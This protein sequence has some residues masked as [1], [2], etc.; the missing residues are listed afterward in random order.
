MSKYFRYC[1]I[2]VMEAIH[3]GA[4][5][6]IN[7]H[8]N[9]LS[10]DFVLVGLLEQDD[11][12]AM[13]TIKEMGL[14]AEEIKEQ[15]LEI[16]DRVYSSRESRS[17]GTKTLPLQIFL[18]RETDDVLQAAKR[19]AD[20]LKDKYISAGVLFLALFERSAGLTATI[21]K[22]VG[23]ER[24]KAKEALI[25]L[26]TGR[27]IDDRHAELQ[28]EI[29]RKYTTDLTEMARRGELDPLIARDEEIKRVI[30]ILSRR[31]KN[32]PVLIGEPGVGKT[33]IVEGLAQLIADADVPETLLNKRVFMLEMSEV[34]AG[35]KFRGEF[36]ERLKAIKEE[37]IAGAGRIILFIDELHTVVGAGAMA[38][39][40]DASNM[41]KP[42]LARGQLQCIGATTLEDYKK[43][44][45]SDKA[46]ERRFQT[47]LIRQPGITETYKILKGL[48]GKYEQHHQVKYTQN[49]LM[50]ASKLSERY[51]ADRFLPDKAID[52]LDEAGSRKRLE[53][54]YIPPEIRRFQ[55]KKDAL[56][57]SQKEAY[58]RGNFEQAA[59]CQQ[60]ILQID[61]IIQ[62]ER[63]KWREKIQP[64][65]FLIDEEQ[66][67]TVVGSW[68]GIPVHRMLET[69]AEKLTHMEEKLH[70]R[71]VGQEYAIKAVSDSIR[72]NRAGLKE[73]NRPIGSFIF[74]GP[75]GVGKTELAKAL[76]EFLLDDENKLLRL[77]MS[78][79][80]E[81]HSISKIIGSPPGYIGY[82]E[83][84]QLTEKVR[85]NPYS[86]I[87]L[88]ELEKAHPDVFN[89]LLQ[90]LDDGRLTDAQGRT[91]NFKN[92][93]IVGTSNLGTESIY[94]D[95]SD[96][97][98]GRLPSFQRYED[99]KS[100][101]MAQARKTF[102]PEFLNRL[103]DLIVFHPLSS[104]LM[105]QIVDLLLDKLSRRLKE[106]QL[107]IAICDEVKDYLTS[108]GFEPKFGARPLKRAI[109]T[110]VE[111][112]LALKLINGDFQSGDRIEL[113]IEDKQISFKKEEF[114]AL[115]TDGSLLQTSTNQIY[116][117]N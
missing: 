90:I 87:L 12:I 62:E 47:I 21:L 19:E 27:S 104:E 68:T 100:K 44:V 63:T 73:Q 31:K 55:K 8:Q 84:G 2:K 111:N 15:I 98:F 57:A 71:V 59:R 1:T 52:L 113:F 14:S 114:P 65:D 33:V 34:I 9:E 80:M 38:G 56:L 70:R 112:Q 40:L 78:E 10:P 91:V 43:Y 79:Y 32:N 60:K 39:G 92:T 102:K 24:E 54:I 46:L 3:L 26:R 94:N 106:R 22:E 53:L 28:Y 7:F 4:M 67:A 30:Q 116:R 82:G 61:K 109:E 42:A 50:A 23:L 74:L 41:L 69:E 93:I 45:E 6:M 88:D 58:S 81:R 11:S 29:L 95:G 77:D 20:F 66:I 25:K 97:G 37:V 49:A 85:R 107:E 101:I 13:K 36:E 16:L 108:V 110:L 96:I 75:T 89:I 105:R 17:Q 35:A 76:A 99:I 48:Q 86:V 18:S 117:E 5:E 64:E 72:R 115:Q 83:G 51:I 103:D